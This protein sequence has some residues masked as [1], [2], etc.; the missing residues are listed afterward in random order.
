LTTSRL[1][2]KMERTESSKDLMGGYCRGEKIRES[3]L[4]QVNMVTKKLL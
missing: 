2:D 3:Y 1:Y 4:C